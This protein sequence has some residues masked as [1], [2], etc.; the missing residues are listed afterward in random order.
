MSSTNSKTIDICIIGSGIVGMS[1]AH[2]IIER[3]PSLS[4]S[5]VEKEVDVGLHGSGRNSGVLHAGLYY[6]PGSIKANICVKGGRRLLAWCEDEGLPVLKCGKV[7]T[8]QK[9][10]LDSQL[11]ILLKYGRANGA[12][13]EL[14]D[15]QQFHDIV[16]DGRTSTGRAIFSADTCVVKPILVINNLK[17]NLQKKGVKFLFN[18]KQWNISIKR[19]TI[20]FSNGSRLHYSHII[21][22]AGLYADKIAH[23]FNVGKEYTMLPFKGSY[24]Q[25]KKDA[26][27]KFNTNLY[28]VPDLEVPFLGVH[29]TPSIDG[30]IYLGPTATPALGRENYDGLRGVEPFMSIDFFRHMAV[31]VMINEKMRNYVYNQ[32]FDW[33]PTNFLSSIRSIVP[34]IEM[35]HIE[36]SSKVGIRPQLYNKKSRNLVQDFLMLDGCSSTHII[37]AISPAF[38][39]SFEL[40]DYI[41]DKS[42][43]FK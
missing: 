31:Q 20:I 21:N 4:I 35:S 27:F 42:K 18:Q 28:P 9:P 2:Q 40:A 10:E 25:L 39:A 14:I 36:K 22:C 34:Q 29:V 8:P 6:K 11:D 16:P 23:Q 37:N 41:L 1:I 12:S 33:T 26:P 15:E 32:A 38:T 5:I 43:Y 13:V 3:F 17:R 30:V 24:W 7:V 19:K